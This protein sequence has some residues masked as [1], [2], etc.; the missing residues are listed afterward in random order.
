MS[1]I[2]TVLGFS[3]NYLRRYWVR[4]VASLL[5][6]AVFALAN[7]SFIWATRTLAGRWEL[8][9]STTPKPLKD[10]A[11]QIPETIERLKQQ[12]E[13][14]GA[15]FETA[16]DPWLPRIKQPLDWRQIVGILCFIPAIVFVRATADYLNNYYIGWVSE[17]V[18]RDMRLDLMAKFSS[19]SLDFFTRF[20]SGDLLT[21][22]NMDTQTL[23]RCMRVGGADAI[24]ETLTVVTVFSGL[25]WLDWRLTLS[26]LVVVPLFLGPLFVLGKKARRAT[27]SALKANVVQSSQLVE[28]LASIRV[29][30]AFSLEEDQLNRFRKTSK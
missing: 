28:L 17:R 9:E 16:I 1:S 13:E 27:R 23:L 24:K 8:S 11:A 14:L 25:C 15:A 3:W 29:V 12:V 10:T 19:L 5:L 21:R 18:I 7:A 20:K 2:A 22:I 4:L 30:K 6:G 26:T